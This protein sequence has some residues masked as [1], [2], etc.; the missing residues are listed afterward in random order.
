[1]KMISIIKSMFLLA[2]RSFNVLVIRT[3]LFLFHIINKIVFL[4]LFNLLVLFE[5]CEIHLMI[6]QASI[7]IRWFVLWESTFDYERPKMNKEDK[8]P[9]EFI[10]FDN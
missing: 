1:M 6:D 5:R 8:I 7:D 4:F 10:S 9:I 2:I 3:A